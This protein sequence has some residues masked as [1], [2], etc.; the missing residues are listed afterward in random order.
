MYVED[1]LMKKMLIFLCCVTLLCSCSSNEQNQTLSKEETIEKLIAE[2]NYIILDVRTKEEYE[3]SH[4]KGAENIP[5]DEIDDSI[6]LD[7]NKTI[8]VYCK[9]GKRSSIAKESLKKLGYTVYDMGAF[10]TV[11]LDKE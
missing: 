5:Y 10:D 7:K 8:M 6:T 3:E 1:K 11:P 9:S 2:D 4:I